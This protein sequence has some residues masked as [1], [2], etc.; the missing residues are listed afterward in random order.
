[1]QTILH[2][3]KKQA[4]ARQYKVHWVMEYPDEWLA[5]EKGPTDLRDMFETR[6]ESQTM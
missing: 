1:M 2:S 3:N 4:K 5:C 6:N